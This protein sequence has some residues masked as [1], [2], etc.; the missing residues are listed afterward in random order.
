MFGI[1]ARVGGQ[2]WFD[3]PQSTEISGLIMNT[4]L[5]WFMVSI[6]QYGAGYTTYSPP[7]KTQE[8]CQRLQDFAYKLK[9]YD[10]RTKHACIQLNTVK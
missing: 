1:Y 3:L 8:D 4:V 9:A 5:V 7:L 6:S 2:T 10:D